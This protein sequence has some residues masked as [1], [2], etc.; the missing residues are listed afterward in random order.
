MKKIE[1]SLND[2]AIINIQ[3]KNGMIKRNLTKEDYEF[4]NKKYRTI[5]CITNLDIALK[6]NYIDIYTKDKEIT[7]SSISDKH[8][9]ERICDKYGNISNIYYIA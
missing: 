4:F 7:I 6:Q 9:K 8:I 1:L 3:L 5:T 2:T